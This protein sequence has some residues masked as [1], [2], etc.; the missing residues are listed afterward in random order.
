MRNFFKGLSATQLSAGALSAVASFLLSA[1]IGIAGSVIG[2]AVGSVVSA[3]VSQIYQNVVNASSEKLQNAISQR[4]RGSDGDSL[5]PSSA[6][7]DNEATMSM[8]TVM[9]PTSV[10]DDTSPTRG[11]TIIGTAT[12]ANRHEGTAANPMHTSAMRNGNVLR[13]RKVAFIVALVSALIAVAVTAG[14]IL[15]V[16]KGHGTD[17]VV[18]DWVDQ[19]YVERPNVPKGDTST[20][21]GDGKGENG[22]AVAPE[23]GTSSDGAENGTESGTGTNDGTTSPGQTDGTDTT[24][25]QTGGSGQDGTT[26][27]GGT[28][29]GGTGTGESGDSG[30]SNVPDAGTDTSG[31]GDASGTTSDG[32]TATDGSGTSGAGTDGTGTTGS[33]TAR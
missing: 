18:R 29:D 17:S 25:S 1:K 26:V 9:E 11:R 7:A 32:S 28:T 15:M 21:D 31:T 2:V 24:D 33:G 5:E 30:S 20:L 14:I 12:N 16:T 13:N 6:D 4:G 22:G 8:T 27:D 10:G 3:V 19:T 23:D